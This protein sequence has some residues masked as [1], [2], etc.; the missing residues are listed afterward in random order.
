[1][2]S[3]AHAAALIL[4]GTHAAV[5]ASSD[6]VKVAN[7][8][9]RLACYDRETGRTPKVEP[10][11][12]KGRWNVR[13]EKSVMTDRT[14]VFMYVE[15]NE[16]VDCGWNKG[17][18]IILWLRCHEDK[19]SLIIDT[20]C[21]MTSSDYN[22]YGDVTIRLDDDKAFTYSMNESTDN[23][24]LGLWS[25][26]KSIPL[27]KKMFGKRRMIIR[28]VPYG[29]SPFTATFPIEGVEEA[30]KPLRLQCNW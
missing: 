1:M 12:G 5:A 27:I 21:H 26:G 20:A 3:L 28:A 29:E 6:C 7:D 2:R 9:D 4:I 17:G 14:D 8:L 23:K 19:T 22:S 25:G 18:K 13:S 15:S 24:S 30:V 11:V 10:L 16:V